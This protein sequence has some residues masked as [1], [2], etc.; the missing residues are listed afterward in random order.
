MRQS[1]LV[2]MSPERDRRWPGVV[3]YSTMSSSSLWGQILSKTR[4]S[5]KIEI[6]Q[7]ASLENCGSLLFINLTID[8]S[9]FSSSSSS[10][11]LGA[12][13]AGAYITDG[14]CDPA[15]TCP[16]RDGETTVRVEVCDV[17]DGDLDAL[18]ALDCLAL[19]LMP[20]YFDVCLRGLP[21]VGRFQ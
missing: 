6:S 21:C 20:G 2:S 3:I 10:L 7:S 9:S 5:S 12:K 16:R 15:G 13:T 14:T 11:L 4:P 8:L 17:G 19:A 18:L 1:A